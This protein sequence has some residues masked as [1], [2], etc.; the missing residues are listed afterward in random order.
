MK[1]LL[2]ETAPWYKKYGTVGLDAFIIVVHRIF[3]IFICTFVYVTSVEVTVTSYQA[4]FGMDSRVTIHK[5][6]VAIKLDI[7]TL[8]H[9]ATAKKEN[10]RVMNIENDIRASVAQ[11]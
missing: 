9:N 11:W 7:L 4:L 3:I 2:S 6:L 8:E 5:T 10:V 1:Q